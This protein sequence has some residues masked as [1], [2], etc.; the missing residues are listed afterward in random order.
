MHIKALLRCATLVALWLTAS[1]TPAQ[2]VG[3]AVVTGRVTEGHP[4]KGVPFAT[5][6]LKETRH[7][8]T[9]DA[10]GAFRLE[11]PA[12]SYTLVVSSVGYRT[13]ETAVRLMPDKPEK[14][15]IRLKAADRELGEARVTA[16]RI[17]RV[18][19]TAYNVVAVDTRA[20]QNTTK[21]LADALTALPGL[22]L[23]ESGG[24]GSDM[25]MTLDGFTG[26]HVKVFIDGVPQEGVG[27]AFDLN[28]I[29]VNFAER[30]E[31]YKGVVPVGF[32]TD[33]LGGVINI[34]TAKQRRRWFV[35][36]SYSYGSFNT[37]KSYVNAGQTLSRGLTWEV[38]AF[39]NYSD[40]DYWIDTPVEDFATGA[41][42]RRKPEHVRRFHD[43]YHNEAVQGKLGLTGKS[44]ADRLMLGLT[45]ANFHKEIQNGVLQ[46]VVFG[47]KFREGHSWM[48]S[49]EWSKRNLG[50][51]GLD[52]L[53]TVNYNRNLTHNVDTARTRWNWRGETK[54]GSGRGEQS[55]QDAEFLNENW[56]ATF[57]ANYRLG[58]WHTFTLN[59]VFTHFT[60][61]A[62]TDAS[63]T[64]ATSSLFDKRTAKNITGL[65]YRLMPS[66][67]WN[68]TAFAKYYWTRSEG[69]VAESENS[70]VYL[71][72]SGSSR[73]PGWGVAGTWFPLQTFGL[74]ERAGDV[75]VKLSYER[76][77]RLPSD[78]E[79]F[80]DEDLEMGNVNLRPE[81][82]DNYNLNLSYE[83][84]L[85]RRHTLYVEGGLVLR[86]TKD[87]IMRTTDRYSGNKYYAS[88]NNWGR[89]ITK[90]VNVSARWAW[91]HWLSVGGTFN[92]MNARDHERYESLE[93]GLK[94][95]L[96]YKV[97]IPNQPYLYAN[98]D[99]A[100][101]WRGLG[102]EGNVLSLTYDNYYVHRFPLYW[103]NI[104]AAGKEE[105]P[106]Q[107]SHNLGLTYSLRDGRYNFSLE[108]RNFTNEKLYDNFSLQKA[109]RAFYG[110]VRIYFA[111]K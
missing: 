95:S 79:L 103:E 26:K 40:N 53:A 43:K 6:R 41:I 3:Q 64:A 10:K 66:R 99:V 25:Q 29:P 106:T 90:G 80:G 24:V 89:V 44:W 88:Y 67:Q 92:Y 50:V 1:A 105:V 96:T 70:S 60:R 93:T 23:R 65:S 100:F 72:A 20:L 85:P 2:P 34:V 77:Y 7:A 47:G 110:K 14:V 48:P 57:T 37:H 31:V 18:R 58:R 101:H 30:I 27:Q 38:N 87:Y 61:H 21:N 74:D 49:L 63:S 15:H 86:D 94:P 46:T 71:P 5:V 19:Q 42:N 22:K 76:A 62:Q 78:T 39:Q 11:A 52:L 81:R 102:G 98:S 108:C 12:G 54:Q 91:S 84:R 111:G 4:A 55:Y 104:S 73:T 13:A 69:A 17:S 9:T 35:D 28:N 45:W 32:G 97:R 68:A 82:S 51:K 33:A 8:V 75:Q 107:F 83:V 36:A 56:N 109:G 59:N 16:G